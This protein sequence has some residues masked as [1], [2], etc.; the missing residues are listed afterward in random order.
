MVNICRKKHL[1][2][3]TN[4]DSS[5]LHYSNP[6]ARLFKV[7]SVKPWQ[8][9][10]E[11]HPLTFMT[12]NL[13][14]Q[15]FKLSLVSFLW[16]TADIMYNSL[17]APCATLHKLF[18]STSPVSHIVIRNP[19]EKAN[20]S[21]FCCHS[22]ATMLLIALYLHSSHVSSMHEWSANSHRTLMRFMLNTHVTLFFN[23]W[24]QSKR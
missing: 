9:T 2:S 16:H 18:S 6:L 19:L 12:F 22:K 17:P 5:I 3:I 13:S 20:F 4:I 14:N 23:P 11:I 21:A 10:I 1:N 24:A 7:Y 15:S 8:Y